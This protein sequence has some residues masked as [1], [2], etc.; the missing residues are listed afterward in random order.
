MEARRRSG[1]RASP[2]RGLS[3]RKE[4]GE[5][6]AVDTAGGPLPRTG[7]EKKNQKRTAS[8]EVGNDVKTWLVTHVVPSPNS[9]LEVV[10][11]VPSSGAPSGAGAE[12]IHIFLVEGKKPDL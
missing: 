8:T 1:I 2:R 7:F 4:K 6:G 11:L 3:R 10:S 12:K 9:P 5:Q